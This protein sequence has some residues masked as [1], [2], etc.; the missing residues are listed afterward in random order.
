ML[1]AAV[2]VPVLAPHHAVPVAA[3]L[4]AP[5]ATRDIILSAIIERPATVPPIAARPAQT[6][7]VGAGETVESLATAN[8]SDAAAIRWANGLGSGAQPAP[9]T[10][11]LL[12]PGAGALVAVLP[13]ERPSHF[14]LRLG[15]DPRVLLDYNALAKDTARAAG[16][17]LQVPLS[18]AP[19]GALV[20]RYFS[21]APDGLPVIAESHGPDT[22]PYGQCTYYVASRR[23]VSWGGNAWAW[24]ENANGIR[25]EGHV[26]VTGSIVVF[27]NGWF[28]HVAYVD[29]VAPDGS[30]D[31][32]EMNFWANG[33]GWG[34]VDHR[35][36]AAHDWSITGFIY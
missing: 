28:G 33:G 23:D 9:G 6:I 36:I 21:R 8:H 25:P 22:F 3:V 16:S 30:F 15:V 32:A 14:A 7:V 11:L 26:P 31:V 18:A 34:R 4:P 29:S 10:T 19:S 2:L 17:Y 12:P 20:G 27:H 24:F 1:L 35:T 5:H 13:N